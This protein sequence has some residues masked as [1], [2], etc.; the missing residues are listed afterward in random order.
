MRAAWWWIDR[1]RKSTAFTDMTLE[2]QGAYRNLCDEVVL[3]EDGVIP[4][5][6][7]ARASGDAVAWPRL[8]AQVMRWMVRAEGGWTN[9]TALEVKA[10]SEQA[11][12]KQSARAKAGWNKR[13]K[14][15]AAASAAAMPEA[16]PDG[17]HPDPSPD[18]SPDTSTEQTNGV[19]APKRGGR[20]SWSRDACDDWIER[21][22]GTAP[23]GP[24]GKALKPLVGKHGW[25]AVR[26]AW[27]SYLEQAE[28]EYA[29]AARFA[30]TFGRWAG[31]AGGP[32]A[33]P[34]RA[35]QL[36]QSVLDLAERARAAE[37]GLPEG[38]SRD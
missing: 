9:E 35:R 7:L 15:D 25:P 31:T 2:E 26:R 17:C 13:R 4:E 6:S 23:G 3:R 27:R 14:H 36:D 18:P 24:I 20:P 32:R 22:G 5:G 11:S 8:R 38:G 10:K 30:Q 16:M 28:A 34:T 19:P 21:F 33:G 29:S 12:Q 37:R 1:W